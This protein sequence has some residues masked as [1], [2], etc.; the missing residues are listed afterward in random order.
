M[1]IGGNH[2]FVMLHR[3]AD[4]AESQLFEQGNERCILEDFPRFSVEMDRQS[5]GQ[6]GY[7]FSQ[8]SSSAT[9]ERVLA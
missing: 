8:R 7:F 6:G 4:A 9:S 3:D 2:Y 1:L 5:R